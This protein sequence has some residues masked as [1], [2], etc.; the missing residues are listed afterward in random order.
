[1]SNNY[2]MTNSLNLETIYKFF[3]LDG[4][5]VKEPLC[6]SCSCTWLPLSNCSLDG[7]SPIDVEE[8]QSLTSWIIICIFQNNRAKNIFWNDWKIKRLQ[9]GLIP[10]NV[11]QM[12][13]LQVLLLKE[14]VNGWCNPMI[15]CY[16]ATKNMTSWCSYI[17]FHLLTRKRVHWECLTSTSVLH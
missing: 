16:V 2:S 17:F 6:T 12:T 8:E 3:L 9:Q 10:Q 1:M 15:C 7:K 13:S 4:Y 5:F 14:W 11:H